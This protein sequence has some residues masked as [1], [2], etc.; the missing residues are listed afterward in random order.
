M[1]ALSATGERTNIT[2]LKQKPALMLFVVSLVFLASILACAT[3]AEI[4]IMPL[5]NSITEGATG[6]RF[7][8]N[9]GHGDRQ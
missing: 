5:G 6:S 4:R 9:G 8:N 3:E 7:G 1:C 2:G